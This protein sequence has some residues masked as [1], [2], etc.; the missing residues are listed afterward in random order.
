MNSNARSL[1]GGLQRWAEDNICEVPKR[2]L[3]VYSHDDMD[4]AKQ[5]IAAMIEEE[6]AILIRDPE[7]ADEN[8]IC[9][10][11]VA[12][13]GGGSPFRAWKEGFQRRVEASQF[14]QGH[15]SKA[16]QSKQKEGE[17]GGDGDAE[18]AV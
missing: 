12:Y 14:F 7:Q 5:A 9:L 8:D 10:L 16:N 2:I 13:P 1:I 15:L 4:S 3:N 6:S 11:L 18:E 17:Q